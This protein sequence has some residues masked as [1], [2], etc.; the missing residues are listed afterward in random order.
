MAGLGPAIHVLRC[1]KVVDA[2][3]KSGHDEQN[4]KGAKN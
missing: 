4:E 2:R 3:N 1:S